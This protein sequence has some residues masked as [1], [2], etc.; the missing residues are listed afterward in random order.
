[1]ASLRA[2]LGGSSSLDIVVVPGGVNVRKFSILAQFFGYCYFQFRPF[3]CA[4]SE[5]NVFFLF[6]RGSS[7]PTPPRAF[8]VFCPSGQCKLSMLGNSKI[9][10]DCVWRAQ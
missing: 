10:A 7:T 5:I 3:W 2:S 8:V 4:K 1:M 6:G 9:A